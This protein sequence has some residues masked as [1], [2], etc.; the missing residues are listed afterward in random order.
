MLTMSLGGDGIPCPPPGIKQNCSM[1]QISTDGG[2]TWVAPTNWSKYGSNE[3]VPV[4][5]DL[6]TFLSL[7]YST[8]VDYTT[9]TTA[10]QTGWKGSLR[11]DGSGVDVESSVTITY[12]INAS[13][14]TTRWPNRLVHSGSVVKLKSSAGGGHL[15]TLYGHGSGV[16]RKWNERAAVYFVTSNDG[17]VN[18]RLISTIPWRPA[19]G[20]QSDGPGEPTT[21]R[22]NDG[23][24]M[25][26]FRSDSTEYYY[27]AFSNDEGQSWSTPQVMPLAWSVKPRLRLLS[28]GIVILTGG[29][30][31]IFLW[32]SNDVGATWQR[33]SITEKHNALVADPSLKY[34]DEVTKA[35][36]PHVPRA[37]PPETSSYTG[38][39]ISSDG[40][41][42]ISYD[43]LAN[44]WSGPPGKWGNCDALFVMRVHITQ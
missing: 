36:G 26:V 30:P 13:T 3:V 25:V 2:R 33:F 43:R 22:L 28:N 40:A 12:T 44:G 29:R 32:V 11:K 5:D 34:D 23:R 9:N 41:L 18:W 39:A 15:T 31:G 6:G 14:T 16:Y 19:Y 20:N 4:D 1:S 17:G 42:I 10:K 21:A 27:N 37:N 7:G 35:D 24:L 8:E 38:V